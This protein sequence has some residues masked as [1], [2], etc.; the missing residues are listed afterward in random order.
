MTPGGALIELL[1]R[2]GA[3]H[4]EPVLITD[5][6]LS[7]WPAAEVAAM[8]SQG[9][10]AKARPA[11]SVMCPGCEQQCVM[12][13]HTVSSNGRDRRSFVVCDK[14]SDINRVP[15]A[16]EQLTQWRCDAEA[17]CGFVAAS[18]GVR[19]SE[20]RPAD[21]DLIPIG[22][23]SGNK[24]RQMLCLRT[25]GALELV[26]GTGGLPLGEVISFRKGAYS[27]DVSPIRQIVDSATTADPR[28]TP[29]NARREV[30]KVETQERYK[31]W[32]KAFRELK[33]RRPH[34]SDVWYSQQIA[35]LDI[36]VGQRRDH[37][38]AHEEVIWWRVPYLPARLSTARRAPETV[39][40]VEK[41]R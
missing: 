14:R 29:S 6:E 9:L 7:Q 20:A 12:P 2:V 36:A 28:Y 32:Q 13:V 39:R 25:D 19:R 38:E 11:A 17:V 8:K 26:A 5:A 15:V 10:L 3:R 4:G 41:E 35:K 18:L 37:P 40:S 30:R 34:M 24:K 16:R 31:A 33:K 1:A 21:S 23:A 27:L 22:I